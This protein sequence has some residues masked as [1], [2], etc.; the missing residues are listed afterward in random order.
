M[1]WRGARKTA[2]P[3]NLR[4]FLPQ[5]RQ[6]VKA[7]Q[8]RAPGGITPPENFVNNFRDLSG[9][10][11]RLA[12][13]ETLFCDQSPDMRDLTQ[14]LD[15]RLCGQDG[16]GLFA[17]TPASPAKAGSRSE[18]KSRAARD[19]TQGL[20]AR[21]RGQDG[22][23]RFA[24]TPASPAKA[25]AQS[26]RKSRAARVRSLNPAANLRKRS[27]GPEPDRV[28]LRYRRACFSPI[29]AAAGRGLHNCAVT[30]RG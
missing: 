23:G 2:Q 27:P 25:G 5:A 13:P 28:P 21:M 8:A 18:R 3:A 19:L 24:K 29:N 16:E 9:F 22:G 20:D 12:G 4:L 30:D 14:G 7:P 11:D 17:E 10:D 1:R 26:K 6:R 15:A